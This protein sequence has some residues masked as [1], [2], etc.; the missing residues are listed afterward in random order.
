MVAVL[1]ALLEGFQIIGPDWRYLHVNAAAGRHNKRAPAE[2]LG[3]TMMECYPGI[4]N[5]EVFALLRRCME[6][7]TPG[8]METAF[9]FPDGSV[10]HFEVRV[11]PIPQGICA[12]SIDVTARRHAELARAQAEERLRHAQRMEAVGQLA[13]GIAHDFNNLLTAM[14]GQGEIALDRPG[15][16]TREDL[17]TILAAARSSA[18]LT[19]QLLAYGR[20]TVL[21]REV[22]DPADVVQG[23]ERL[24]RSSLV[25]RIELRVDAPR[26]QGRV[27]ADRSQMEQILMNLVVNARDAIPTEGRI[28]VQLSAADLD[29]DYV[30]QHAGAGVGRHMVLSVSDT[31]I[32]MDAAT[33]ARIFEPFFTTKERGRGTGLGLATVYG[34]V[35]QHRG[36]IWVYSEPGKGTTF[37][38]YLP[39]TDRPAIPAPAPAPRHIERAPSRHTVLMVEDDE[40]LGRLLTLVLTGAGYQLLMATRGDDAIKV[41]NEHHGEV[42]LLITDVMVPGVQGP[43]LIRHLRSQRPDLPVICTSG[44]SDSEL[45]SRGSMPDGVVFIEKPYSMKGI[46]QQVDAMLA[47]G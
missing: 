22:I 44:Y 8:S 27:E 24:I 12:L 23:I 19:R 20:R 28:V 25:S 26:G 10:G 45:T 35:K 7:R 46:T 21:L 38:V 6:G 9:T 47:G 32:G 31:G 39:A 43:E 41:W 34:I 2:L 5:S 1:D 29:E 13:A 33:R 14:L 4:E 17:E 3:R 30:R 40:I 36:N 11:E 37:K 16:P 15:G 42:A 18:Q